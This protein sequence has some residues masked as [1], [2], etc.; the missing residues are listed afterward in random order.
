[1]TLALIALGLFAGGVGALVGVGGGIIITPMLALYFGIPMHQ[2]IGAS[3]LAVIATS[4][5]TSSVYLERHVANIRLGMTLELATTIGAAV[6]AV[7]AGY[8]D[9]KTLALLFAA[10]LLYS[11]FSMAQKAWQSR[12][13]K[14]ESGVPDYTVR[15]YG[16]GLGASLVA[17]GFSGLLGIG[18]GPI[19]VPVMYL[20]MGVPLRAATATSNFM[21][22]VTAATSAYIY[23]GRGDVLLSLA[24]PI[25]AGAFAGSL[26]GAR[27]APRVRASNIL[28]LLMAV[29]LYLAVQ[30][31][32]KSL[33]GAFG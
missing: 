20:F 33:T 28:F 1:M 14:H 2:A 26:L 15:R 21:I 24:A 10:F 3:L 29:A 8:V 18:G 22:G 5:A 27:L 11:A 12:A 30:L 23:Y 4:T 6:A 7:I 32:Y 19:K 16:L 25:V 13:A 9:R 17:G 31:L